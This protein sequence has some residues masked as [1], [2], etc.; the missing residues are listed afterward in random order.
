MRCDIA[1]KHPTI[2]SFTRHTCS[3]PETLNP[4]D[5][6]RGFILPQPASPFTPAHPLLH[7]FLALH[8][9]TVSSRSFPEASPQSC[10]DVR[11]SSG[12]LVCRLASMHQDRAR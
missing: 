4:K 9:A 8:S 1:H 2:I 12:D 11:T 10:L 5:L 7:C 3:E 6:V